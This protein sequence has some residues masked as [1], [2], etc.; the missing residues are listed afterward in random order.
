MK[1]TRPL[2]LA[3]GPLRDSKLKRRSIMRYTATFSLL[4]WM[5]LVWAVAAV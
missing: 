1:Q 3:G 4:A 2:V 5:S